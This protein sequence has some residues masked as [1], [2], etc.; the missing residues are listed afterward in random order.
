MRK[1]TKA[2]LIIIS[3]VLLF[4]GLAPSGLTVMAN[5]L[6]SETPNANL[7]VK[8][9]N[10]TTTQRERV[11]LI[12]KEIERLNS[13]PVQQR[14]EEVAKSLEEAEGIDFTIDLPTE[15][16]TFS[17]MATKA[18][19]SISG[20][21]VNGGLNIMAN[22]QAG[23][24]KLGNRFAYGASAYGL[25][26]TGQVAII[27]AF[28]PAAPIAAIAGLLVGGTAYVA[29]RFNTARKIVRGKSKKAGVRFTVNETLDITKR[30][31]NAYAR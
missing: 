26:T 28:A 4:V 18:K 3:G 22:N 2:L 21:F 19:A 31:I 20:K 13:L 7:S 14:N 6:S 9:L 17:I 15:N 10:I 27:A 5:E 1:I 16:E 29:K 24:D 25:S 30:G 11:V 8:E 12:E 23:V